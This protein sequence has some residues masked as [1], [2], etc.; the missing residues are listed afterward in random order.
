[1]MRGRCRLR[2]CL[3]LLLTALWLLAAGCAVKA[4][5][6]L[7]G[8][9]ETDQVSRY[10]AIVMQGRPSAMII[11]LNPDIAPITAANF[12]K[13]VGEGFYDG[14]TF[15]RVIDE[16]LIQ[17]GDPEGTGRGGPGYTIKGEFSVN[18]ISNVLN[19]ERGS[20]SMARSEDYDSAGSQFFIC[21]TRLEDLDRKYAVFGSVIAGME[22]ADTIGAVANSGSPNNRPDQRQVMARVFFVEPD[23]SDAP[24]G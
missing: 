3:T 21:L 12:Q 5:T 16:K 17:G 2:T 9:R 7:H 15:H 22:T 18:G 6:D 13:L 4:E 24:G 8:Y 11:E 23:D 10:V 1:M 19:H 14:L 20:L